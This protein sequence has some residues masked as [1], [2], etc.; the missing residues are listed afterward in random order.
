MARLPTV[1]GDDGNW[2]TILNDY[3][4]QA[5]RSD[6]TLKDNAVTSNA[7]AP[8]SVT[9]AAIA[10]DAVTAAQIAGGSIT[11]T[12]LDSNVQT[13]LNS[14]ED[15]TTL[16]NKPAV[17]AAGADQ[18][19]A[20]AAI[21]AVGR[22]AMPVNVRDYGAIGDGVADDTA[23]IE[24]AF[25]AGSG[26]IYFPPG[27]YLYNGTGLDGTV[28]RITGNG[29]NTVIAL[30][31]SSYL[32]QPTGALNWLDLRDLD[33]LGGK[34]VIKHTGT[35]TDTNSVKVIK[36]CRMIGY[37]ECAIATES[38]DSPYWWVTENWFQGSSSTMGLALGPGLT[39]N[40]VIERNVFLWNRVGVKIGQGG[41]N[42]TIRA[43]AFYR[44]DTVNTAGPRIDVWIV[45]DNDSVNSGIGM[46][47]TNNKFGNEG[48]TA[49][50]FKIVYADES[51]GASNG[52]KF[53]NLGANSAG[54]IRGH[55]ILANHFLGTANGPSPLIYS[56]TPNVWEL[57]V[58]DNHV[59]LATTYALQYRTPLTVPDRNSSDNVYGPFYGLLGIYSMTFP[60]SNQINPGYTD[61]PN[62]VLQTR[63]NVTRQHGSGASASYQNLLTTSLSAFTA[64]NTTI[65]S[66]TDAYGG[67]D[68]AHF[69]F[70][71]DYATV[72]GAL[73]TC[74]PDKPAWV[75]IDVAQP[76]SG[77]PCAAIT[78][79]LVEGSDNTLHWTRVVQVPTTAQGWVTYAF[80]WTPRIA[81]TAAS[82][83]VQAEHQAGAGSTG[84]VKVGRARVYHAN[85]RQ[86]GGRRPAIA[87]A[88]T[89]AGT[90]QT[91][92]NDLRTKLIALGIISA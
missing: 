15:W 87:A 82:L 27:T 69:Q 35:G 79:I 30:G 49:G 34:G 12:L 80:P 36:N 11:E 91:L 78:L 62:H 1:G 16:A 42:T 9:N 83:Y 71:G 17:I 52:V 54:Y 7:L 65:T 13:K 84:K 57:A 48:F 2:G 74:V 18:A 19:A 76:D 43:N 37:T 64:Y 44:C 29:Y 40:C 90:T 56:T 58:R 47:I 70:T 38:V 53:P 45:P 21:G 22:D 20:R 77:T 28:C 61:D 50:D 14:T 51:S 8:N 63:V 92:A 60:I 72:Y 4:S 31:A 75:E 25:T 23:A 3:L 24:A 67:A 85:E 10:T 26:H 32:L 73:L 33:I 86:L 6:G 55:S 39:D 89:D 68:A 88:A 5:H 81:G 41:N 59:D 66:A 46:T